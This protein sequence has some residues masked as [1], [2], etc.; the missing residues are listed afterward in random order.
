MLISWPFPT[1]CVHSFIHSFTHLLLQY[2]EGLKEF[3]TETPTRG[4]GV[5]RK[6][7]WLP[8]FFFAS[9]PAV[10]RAGNDVPQNGTG[11]GKTRRPV[12]DG[13]SRD[14]NPAGRPRS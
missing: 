9:L 12:S 1:S 3:S 14:R 2:P 5:G 8:R 7:R 13:P 11:H 10:G 6:P 4:F